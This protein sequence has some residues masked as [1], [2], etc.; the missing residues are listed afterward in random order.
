[1]THAGVRTDGISPGPVPGAS[2]SWRVIDATGSFR[3]NS[4]STARDL[5]ARLERD[6]P[7]A[8]PEMRAVEP[9]IRVGH[10][11]AVDEPRWTWTGS[12]MTHAK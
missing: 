2:R 10:E 6:E 7:G 4:T 1:M 3:V 9:A 11:Q 5:V 8:D 12:G